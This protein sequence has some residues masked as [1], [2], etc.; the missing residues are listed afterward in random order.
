M[1]YEQAVKKMNKGTGVRLP[2]HLGSGYVA[3]E[4]G[5]FGDIRT[6]GQIEVELVCRNCGI[7]LLGALASLEDP[8]TIQIYPGHHIVE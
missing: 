4:H 8:S 1:E 7:H 5:G 6:L 2:K 3:E